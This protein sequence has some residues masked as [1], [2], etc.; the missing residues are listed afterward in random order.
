MEKTTKE[1]LATIEECIKNIDN[2]IKRISEN[3]TNQWK[4]I[5]N[6]SQNIAGIKGA[7]GV[8][9]GFVTIIMNCLITYFIKGMN[10]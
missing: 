3:N 5:N 10:K 9:A 1:R 2:N 8:I 7:S 6:N 4:A